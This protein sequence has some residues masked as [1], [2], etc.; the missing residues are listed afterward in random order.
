MPSRQVTGDRLVHR[1]LFLLLRDMAV[2]PRGKHH[3]A[4]QESRLA[5]QPIHLVHPVHILWIK[6]VRLK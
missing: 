2:R 3:V 5:G 1:Q 4:L 6:L